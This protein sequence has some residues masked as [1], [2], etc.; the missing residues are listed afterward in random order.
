[1][2]ANYYMT[3]WIALLISLASWPALGDTYLNVYGYAYHTS[4]KPICSLDGETCISRPNQ[5]NYGLGVRHYQSKY[6]YE[7]GA[8]IDSFNDW[9]YYG[10]AGRDWQIVGPLY[11]GGGV[12]IMSR[13]TYRNYSPFLGVLPMLS[14]KA[15]RGMLH[16]AYIPEYEPWK[17]RETYF[18]YGSWNLSR[19]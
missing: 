16:M 3:R 5:E 11:A 8:F 12:F 10:G 2:A 17:M 1:M 18:L 15:G 4:Q 19:Y 9:S 14:I 7:G 13:K 6:F